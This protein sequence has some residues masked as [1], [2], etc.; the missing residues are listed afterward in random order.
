MIAA[1]SSSSKPGA[2]PQPLPAELV[3]TGPPDAQTFLR[4]Q[5]VNLTTMEGGEDF[6]D[7]RGRNK[8]LDLTL[9]TTPSY[10]SRLRGVV[11][12]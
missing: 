10:P 5:R 8:V 9:F 6:T 7:H 2:L 12:L 4:A 3:E 11:H 1:R